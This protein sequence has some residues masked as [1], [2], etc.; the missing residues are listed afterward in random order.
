MVVIFIAIPRNFS[1]AIEVAPLKQIPDVF[2]GYDSTIGTR[3]S[4]VVETH[5]Q[6]IYLYELGHEIKEIARFNCST[7]KSQGAKQVEGDQKT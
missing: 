7:G 5:S 2:V 1:H 3:Y 6:L 4:I